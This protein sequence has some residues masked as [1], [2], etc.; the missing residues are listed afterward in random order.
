MIS[1]QM[2]VLILALRSVYVRVS[3]FGAAFGLNC[4]DHLYTVW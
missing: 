3:Y 2:L 1:G 4:Q